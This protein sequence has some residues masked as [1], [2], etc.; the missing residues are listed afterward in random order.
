[1]SISD[2]AV[3]SSV[4]THDASATPYIVWPA[5]ASVALALDL[6]VSVPAPVAPALDVAV[7]V[8]VSALSQSAAKRFLRSLVNGRLFYRC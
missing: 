3:V 5:V 7:P 6:A 2:W 8:G 4:G 1:M